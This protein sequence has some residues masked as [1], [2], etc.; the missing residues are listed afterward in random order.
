MSCN[1]ENSFESVDV[2]N[3]GAQFTTADEGAQ[4][5]TNRES[6][7]TEEMLLSDTNRKGIL[8]KSDLD[9]NKPELQLRT[10]VKPYKKKNV[11]FVRAKM[12]KESELEVRKL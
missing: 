12:K 10:R 8:F 11:K 9:T 6:V 1:L 3:M 2:I 4:K 5:M 7:Q